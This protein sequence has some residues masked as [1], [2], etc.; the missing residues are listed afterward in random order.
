MDDFDRAVA[1]AADVHTIIK[2]YKLK[3]TP[4]VYAIWFAY[5]SREKPEL[6]Q[7]IDILI[8]NKQRI[9]EQIHNDLYERFFM[10]D[11]NNESVEEVSRN[12]SDKIDRLMSLLETANDGISDF[13][14][15]MDSS[16]HDMQ[17]SEDL[18]EIR[19][20][21]AGLASEARALQEKNTSL[22]SKLG[23]ASREI[24]TLRS[25][26]Q[27]VSREA[28]TDGLTGL[29]NRK[30]VDRA[31]R[32]RTQEALEHGKQLFVAMLDIDHFKLFND[33][34]GHQVGDEVLRVVASHLGDAV[35]APH[36][37]GRYGGEEF[38]MIFTDLRLDQVYSQCESLRDSLSQHR[39]QLSEMKSG[40]DR[41]TVSIGVAKYELGE[42]VTEFVGRADAG[43]YRAK[44]AGR[45]RTV[46]EEF[47]QS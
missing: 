9:T 2:E 16:L 7:A 31:L 17:S 6:V 22:S 5:L 15:S 14:D 23:E 21:V 27:E 39:L 13:G 36:M 37:P 34:H 40:P 41:I 11:N 8:S 29:G 19:K 44:E 1:T 20:I 24:Q 12:L 3:P 42:P 28:L 46:I 43:L 47:G 26:L 25:N 38:I 35:Q 30:A 10:P 4:Q 45:N 33:S 32:D 18:G